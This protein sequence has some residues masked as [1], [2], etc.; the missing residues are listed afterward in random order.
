MKTKV[1]WIIEGHQGEYS[2]R[3]E[4]PV[5]YY[6]DEKLAKEHAEKAQARA[7]ELY[8]LTRKDGEE[9]F[10]SNCG[11]CY[12]GPTSMCEKHK[13]LKNEWDDSNLDYMDCNEVQ[14]TSYPV[15]IG[16]LSK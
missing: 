1:V 5:A 8:V 4:W 9:Y 14:Y 13:H 2:D 6:F 7:R 16:K 10:E 12:N 11:D 3:S 15:R